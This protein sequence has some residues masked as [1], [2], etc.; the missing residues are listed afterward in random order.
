M[1]NVSY[2]EY[3]KLN[4]YLKLN[5]YQCEMYISFLNII[6]RTSFYSQHA[7]TYIYNVHFY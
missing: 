7:C 6:Q 2:I 5:K 3:L 4:R 1:I